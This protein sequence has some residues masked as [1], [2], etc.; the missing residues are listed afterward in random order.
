M[1]EASNKRRID[2][3]RLYAPI[4]A[5]V[6]SQRITVI[7]VSEVG[8][9]IEHTFPL[10][11]G[12]TT[13]ITFK[14]GELNVAFECNVVRCKL[15]RSVIGGALS[16]TSGL[17][18]VRPDDPS[19]GI[20]LDVLHKVVEED[21]GARRRLAAKKKAPATKAPAKKRPAKKAASRKTPARKAAA[22]KAAVKKG[23]AKTR[24]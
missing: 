17:R 8:A 4:S 6:E 14:Y 23:R 13:L 3:V 16:Y 19:V 1:A 5:T 22:K 11:T 10:A 12:S 21:L 15:D 2:R 20:L 18:F 7:D 9:R 24:T